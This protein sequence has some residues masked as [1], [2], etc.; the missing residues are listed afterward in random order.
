MDNPTLREAV[1]EVLEVSFAST[2][3]YLYS[4]FADKPQ[5]KKCPHVCGGILFHRTNK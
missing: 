1:G 3:S 5:A 4:V 2:A